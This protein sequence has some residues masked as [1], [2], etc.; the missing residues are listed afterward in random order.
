MGVINVKISDET[1]AA[2]RMAIL[3]HKGAKKGAMGEAVEEALKL[4]IA[5]FEK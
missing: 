5:K 1:E 3:K 2:F 4:W